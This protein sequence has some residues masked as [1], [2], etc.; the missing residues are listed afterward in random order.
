MY[1]HQWNVVRAIG[2]LRE[3]GHSVSLLLIGGGGGRA[4]R[5]L[6]AEI[7]RTDPTREFVETEGFVGHEDVRNALANSDVFIFASTCENLPITLIEAM[8]SGLPIACSDRG[9]MPEVLKD[10]GVYFD[11]EDFV[12]ISTA[13]ERLLLN[14][15]LRLSMGR[16]AAA[17]SEQYSWERC[18]N[19]TWRF[20]RET[21]ESLTS[22][23][24]PLSRVAIAADRR[25]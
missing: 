12:S 4:Q 8:A 18:G 17:L 2:R 5:L 7:S 9:P 22:E 16:R 13:I 15:D 10:G 23:R 6:E 20:L 14:Q 25:E 19:E 11:P 24:A 21:I 1:K 3:R